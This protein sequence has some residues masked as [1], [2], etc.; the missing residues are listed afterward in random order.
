MEVL[1]KMLCEKCKKK[2]ASVHIVKMV[3]G[4]KSDVWLCEDCA[5]KISNIAVG[6]AGS[7]NEHS[8]QN[9]IGGLFE[10][11]DKYSNPKMDVICKNCGLTYSEFNKTK[12]AGCGKCYESFKD[13]LDSEIIEVQEGTFHIGKIPRSYQSS[14]LEES[15]ISELREKLKKAVL[16]EEYEEA[17]SIRDKIKFLENSSKGRDKAYEKLDS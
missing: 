15:S 4:Q 17:A 16:K 1:K 2:E 14:V 3:N 13:L 7:T 8:I 6:V 10:E 9:I 5:K 11:L 12:E